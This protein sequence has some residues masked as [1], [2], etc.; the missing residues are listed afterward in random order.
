VSSIECVLGLQGYQL[1][2]ISYQFQ[3]KPKSPGWGPGCCTF[4]FELVL[5]KKNETTPEVLSYQF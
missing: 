2:V 1:S 4:S 3:A 5:P